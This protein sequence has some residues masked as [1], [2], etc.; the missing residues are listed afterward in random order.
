M[1]APKST[2]SSSGQILWAGFIVLIALWVIAFA[3]HLG[4]GVITYLVIISLAVLL[5]RSA[6][7]RS[8]AASVQQGDVKSGSGE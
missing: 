6:T 1:K 2:H 8:K 3:A 4:G 5:I 7:G